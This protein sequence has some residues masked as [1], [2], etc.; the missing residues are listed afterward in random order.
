VTTM[1]QTEAPS[2]F[3]FASPHE[4]LRELIT[5]LRPVNE[6]HVSL[7]D[8]MGRILSRPIKA[9]R[10]SPPHDV[11]A[12]DGYAVRSD[13]I[14]EGVT[15]DVMAEIAIGQPPPVIPAKGCLKISTGACVP[16]GCDGIIPR[17]KVNERPTQITLGNVKPFVVGQHIRRRGENQ[18]SGEQV[19][20]KGTAITPPVA[21]AL[22]AFGYAE[23]WVHRPVRVAILTTGNELQRVA[24]TPEPWQIRDSN[25]SALLAGLTNRPWIEIITVD[26]IMDDRETLTDALRSVAGRA[27]LI[28]TT[29]GVSMGDHDYL[30]P[31][32][33][34]VGGRVVYH[35]LPI[36]PGKPS[37]GGLI[38]DP[39]QPNRNV[40]LVALPGNPVAVAVG[41]ALFVGPVAWALAGFANPQTPRT[42][43]F[44]SN[45]PKPKPGL[46]RYL[47]AK[48]TEDGIAELLTTKGSGDLAGA[49][50][51]DGY[52]EIPPSSEG[53]GPWVFYDATL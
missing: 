32:L 10:D 49:A 41:I 30:K 35:K 38:A 21:G 37:L 45:P 47:P 53:P 14:A 52:V 4:A 19:V 8:A 28:V 16:E 22:A 5:E 3:A 11:S 39:A 34:D 50:L 40:A 23:V 2:P 51:A 44:I 31:A 13:G 33:L 15:L 26:R 48:R 27:D 36:R 25:G 46:W 18:Q 12:M 24:S 17:E 29:G 9:D 43:T 42:K 20:P 1:N 6:E 7:D